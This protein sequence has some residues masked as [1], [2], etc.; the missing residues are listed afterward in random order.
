MTHHCILCKKAR[1][2]RFTRRKDASSRGWDRGTHLPSWYCWSCLPA[3]QGRDETE[4]TVAPKK[5]AAATP[6]LTPVVVEKAKVQAEG[7]ALISP[8]QRIVEELVVETAD[9]YLQADQI[10]GRVKQA[11]RT[12]GER[13]E[14]IIRPIRAGLDELYTLNREVDKPL[15]ALESAVEVKMKA[16]KEIEAREISE[17]ERK[18]FEEQEKLRREIEEKTRREEA[19]RTNQMREKLAKARKESEEKLTTNQLQPEPE[20]VRGISS[21]TRNRKIVRVVDKMAFLTGIVEELVHISMVQVDQP[22]INKYFK[23][24]PTVVAEWPGIVIEDDIQIVGR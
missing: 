10:F 16:F 12:W 20:A 23:E 17:A 8:L 3:G 11:R 6:V 22:T 15:A 19:A 2:G 24:N 13:M 21:S 1:E 4:Q 7:L 5:A 18:R 14:R 9:D